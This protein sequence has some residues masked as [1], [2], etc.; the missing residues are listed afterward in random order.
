MANQSLKVI[1]ISEIKKYVGNNN[2]NGIFLKDPKISSEIHP[3]GSVINPT[4]WSK[5]PCP[6]EKNCSKSF[7][8]GEIT[9]KMSVDKI[10]WF[11]RQIRLIAIHKKKRTFIQINRQFRRLQ[12]MDVFANCETKTVEY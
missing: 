2:T 5:Y 8:F 11:S 7:C 12:G 1:P 4:T 6:I 3:L 10:K 9:I